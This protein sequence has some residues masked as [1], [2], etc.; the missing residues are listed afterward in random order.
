MWGCHC[1]AK[2]LVLCYLVRP[3]IL[4]IFHHH[5]LNLFMFPLSSVSLSLT[6]YMT[7]MLFASKSFYLLLPASVLD[8]SA[9]CRKCQRLHKTICQKKIINLIPW[10]IFTWLFSDTGLWFTHSHLHAVSRRDIG[11]IPWHSLSPQ[12]S[13]DRFYS[14][15]LIWGFQ[16]GCAWTISTCCQVCVKISNT[17]AVLIARL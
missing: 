15:C 11:V 9:E 17:P 5:T 14:L 6:L 2:I 4:C 12:A 16:T 7:H 10:T 13:K 8:V 3:N 1:M